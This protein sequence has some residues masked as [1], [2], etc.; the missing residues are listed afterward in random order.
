M[1]LTLKLLGGILTKNRSSMLRFCR[2]VTKCIVSCLT[3]SYIT[4]LEYSC[5][6]EHPADRAS[7]AHDGIGDQSAAQSRG[8]ISVNSW[9]DNEVPTQIE[10]INCVS[11]VQWPSP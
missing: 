6:A 10:A 5:T 7:R 11:R 1:T 4:L 9:I 3:V 8:D 2:V